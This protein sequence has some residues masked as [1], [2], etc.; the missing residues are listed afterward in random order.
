MLLALALALP[1]SVDAHGGL[2]PLETWGDFQPP[3][4]AYCQRVV[5]VAAAGCALQV[6]RLQHKCLEAQASGLE[7]DPLATM[8]AIAVARRDALDL[9]DEH[10]SESTLITIGYTGNFDF[11]TDLVNFCR[12]WEA[13]S[14]SAAY[15]TVDVGSVALDPVERACVAATAAS[16]AKL[17]QSIFDS[18]QTTMNRIAVR[19]WDL[20]AKHKMIDNGS[21]RVEKIEADAAD[22]LGGRCEPARFEAIYHRSAAQL[23]AEVAARANCFPTAFYLQD[24]L[25]CPASICGNWII[26]P[27]ESCDDGNT[28]GGDGCDAECMQTVAGTR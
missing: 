6:A 13:I 1:A 12:Q 19:S 7:C 14:S 4:A 27:G 17:A 15:G 24:K 8:A 23:V 2:Q 26:E 25:V 3:E 16:V 10:C 28:A 18:W 22:A 9:V 5:G 21:A 20:A 11:Q